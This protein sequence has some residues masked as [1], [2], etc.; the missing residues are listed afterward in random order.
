MAQADPAY[1]VRVTPLPVF[2][3][4]CAL[5]L[6]VVSDAFT[7]VLCGC[8]RVSVVQQ[9]QCRKYKISNKL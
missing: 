5:F 2:H 3:S 7:I 8:M 1:K 6:C 4:V 9:L